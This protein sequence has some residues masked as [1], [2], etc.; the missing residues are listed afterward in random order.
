MLL[1]KLDLFCLQEVGLRKYKSA[2][3]VKGDCA[4]YAN[5]YECI[6]VYAKPKRR[7]GGCSLRCV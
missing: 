4:D 1:S 2:V 6:E 7:K 5:Q 3:F